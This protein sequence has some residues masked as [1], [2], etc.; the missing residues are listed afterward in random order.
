MKTLIGST[1][2]KHY[3]P[4]FREPK[5]IDYFTDDENSKG[6]NFYHPL[7]SE[8]AFGDL[9][10]IDELYTIKVSHS[11]WELKNG[12]WNKHMFDILFLRD[13][14]AQFIPELYSLLYK[15]WEDTHG[16]KKANLEQSPEDFF[17]KNVKRVYEHDS[18]HRS[19]AYYNE[20]MFNKIL[21]DGH[22]VAVDKSK[23][24]NLSKKDKFKLIREEVFAT[25]LER[26][27]IPSEYSENYRVAY[28]W[29]LRKTIISFSKGWFPLYIVL[30]FKEL[31]TPDHNYV[32]THKANE[33][34]LV[35][36]DD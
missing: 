30:N 17:N 11:F 7:L 2:I 12:S 24:E 32:K 8:W 33:N 6:D 23:F 27:M 16:K 14:G 9:A 10:T 20:P 22:A 15:V 1:A 21:R 25:A 18:I 13:R 34:L 36:L 29:A 5:D 4:D 26:R 19:V 31:R 3:F 35:L 28:S